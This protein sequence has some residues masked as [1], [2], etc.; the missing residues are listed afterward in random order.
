MVKISPYYRAFRTV[1]KKVN[2]VLYLIGPTDWAM[3]IFSGD[4]IL[5][6]LFYH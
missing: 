3:S 1:K 2:F 5:S 4:L 6:T